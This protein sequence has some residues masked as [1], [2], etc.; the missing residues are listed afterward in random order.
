MRRAPAATP[1]AIGAVS[2][3]L[4]SVSGAASLSTSPVPVK[5]SARNE[6]TPAAGTGFFTWAKSRRGHPHSYD[7]WAEQQG[8]PA[9]KVN[10]LRTSAFGGGVDGTTLVYQQLKNSNS[11]IRLF[12]LAA[13]RRTSAPAG[14]NT[15]NWEWGPSVSGEWLLF[16]RGVDQGTQRAILQNLVTGEQRLLD[17]KR[18]KRGYLIS[19]QV[20]GNYAVWSKCLGAACD[21]FRY[22]ITTAVRTVLPRNGQFLYA[23]SV[24][25][26]GTTYYMRGKAT[27]GGAEFVKTTLDGTTFVLFETGAARDVTLTSSV[28]QPGR[29]PNEPQSVRVYFESERCSTQRFDVYSVDDVEPVPPPGPRTR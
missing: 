17:T 8:Q 29:P 22:D 26:S 25:P 10:A 9:F 23:P 11:D 14:V 4:I 6:L 16:F 18:G 2:L 1:I 24:I 3:V 19:G 7:V 13:R 12:D 28:A 27:C 5:A 15:A 20:N 21:V